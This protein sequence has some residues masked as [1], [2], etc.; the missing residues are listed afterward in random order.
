M[1]RKLAYLLTVALA[2]GLVCVYYQHRDLKGR[3]HALQQ[4]QQTV[5]AAQ[6]EVKKLESEV[7]ASQ[8][9]VD[10]INK[11]PVEMEATIRRIKQLARDG[12]TVYRIEPTPP[13]TPNTSQPAAGAEP[14]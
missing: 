4:N 2:A 5:R 9:R 12:E 3:Y 1:M 10:G 13:A 11:D 6:E 7:E 14:R 8:K